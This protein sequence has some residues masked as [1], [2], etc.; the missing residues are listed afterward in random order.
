MEDDSL[1]EIFHILSRIIAVF[2]IIILIIGL[3]IR[4]NQNKPTIQSFITNQK[5][6][7][8]IPSE[9]SITETISTSAAELN[10]KGPFVCNFSSPG[11]TVSA[12]VKDNNAYG[13]FKEQSKTSSILLKGDC[14]YSWANSSIEGEKL[15]GLFPYISIFGQ[16][17]LVN[18]LGNNQVL[19]LVGR[20]GLNQSMIPSILD[21]CKKEEIKD[22]S[23]FNLPKNVI[24]KESKTK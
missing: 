21:S 13:Q 11:A 19:S 20:F 5:P 17:P 23:V 24:F 14:I 6:T 4:F 7:I 16:T 22:E 15:C 3:I 18:L 10:L 9:K 1:Y 12:F 8:A 2:A